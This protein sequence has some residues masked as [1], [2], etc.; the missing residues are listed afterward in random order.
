[1]LVI[2]LTGGIASGKS[3]VASCFQHL[4]ARILDAD[5]IGH[6]VLRQPGTIAVIAEMWPEVIDENGMIDR[7]KLGYLVFHSE[8][9]SENLHSLEGIVHPLIE[10]EIEERLNKLRT[11]G[12]SAVILDAPVMIKAGWHLKC[13]K[14]IFVDADLETRLARAKQRGWTVEELLTREKLQ[15][16]IYLK[17]SLASDFIDNNH[18]I[19]SVDSQVRALWIKW[20]LPQ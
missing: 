8:N 5:Q 12:V 20:G 13:D 1:M 18:N 14:L 19:D 16:E 3:L 11:E 17:K 2:G 9:A 7:S 6:S 4:G 15:T 10:K